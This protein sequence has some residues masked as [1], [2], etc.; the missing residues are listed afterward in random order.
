[1]AVMVIWGAWRFLGAEN[2]WGVP[3]S[4][5]WRKNQQVSHY[6]WC[7][8]FLAFIPHLGKQ[9]CSSQDG[10]EDVLFIVNT[11]CPGP[12]LEPSRERG[13]GGWQPFSAGRAALAQG[14]PCTGSAHLGPQHVPLKAKGSFEEHS[15]PGAV[16]RPK[17]LLLWLEQEWFFE[18]AHLVD[19][20]SLGFSSSSLVC[21]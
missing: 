17:R 20:K 19:E 7:G 2:L 15:E 9:G 13:R 11:S 18:L 1:M 8:G 4:P 21:V 5:H 3:S 14:C 16:G 12:R 6:L 10:F